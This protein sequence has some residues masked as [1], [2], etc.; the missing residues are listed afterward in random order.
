[1]WRNSISVQIRWEGS[2]SIE[3]SYFDMIITWVHP[4]MWCHAL[5]SVIFTSETL[6]DL[7]LAT[8]SSSISSSGQLGVRSW[9]FLLFF[10]EKEG[11]SALS[12]TPDHLT[13]EFAEVL[14]TV[15]TKYIVFTIVI[16]QWHI[17]DNSFKN[18]IL[19]SARKH[20]NGNETKYKPLSD[21]PFDSRIN[22]LF[23]VVLI[24]W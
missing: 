3:W 14:C 11:F 16:F 24:A 5:G 8:F 19:Y 13:L 1:M 2:I 23:R 7:A 18:Q 12:S 4:T 20:H 17:T 10:S 22:N 6:Q 15:D 9:P 21:A